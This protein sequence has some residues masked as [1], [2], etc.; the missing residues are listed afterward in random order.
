VLE[1]YE[2]ALLELLGYTGDPIATIDA[3][4]AE[5]PA[6]VLGH[7]FRAGALMT[8]SERRY[9]DEAARSVAAA[10]ALEGAANDRERGL[11]AASRALVDGEWAR[12]C[13][14]YEQV[15]I[16]HPRDAFA[17]QVAHLFDYFRGDVFNL[18]NRVAR[19]LPQWSAGLPSYSYVLGMYAFGLEENHQYAE[20]ERAARAA[21]ELERRDIWAV[22]AAAHCME[23]V[24]RVEEGIG[25]LESRERDWAPGNS[26]AFHNYWHLALFHWDRGDYPGV[27]GIYDRVF[28]AETDSALVLLDATALLWRLHLEGVACGGR[29]ERLAELWWKKVPGEA[30]F[31]AFN[32]FHA[33]LAFA[34]CG[35]ERRVAEVIE[36]IDPAAL[37]LARGLEDFARGR[38]DRAADAL[39]NARETAHRFGGSHAQRDVLTLT[40]IEAA[41]RAGRTSLARHVLAE[42]LVARPGGGVGRRISARL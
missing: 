25:W 31:Y 7:V 26:F 10:E 35:Q 15:L 2:R 12:A 30:G 22:H 18:K 29:M 36:A 42:R 13:S 37:P 6:F 41:R 17:I 28:A 9:R 5:E 16:D 33:I 11:I 19:V 38:F 4:L 24:G 20:A 8:L 34:A 1:V 21:L 32:D 3:A 14:L 40:L 39:A 27:L 23:M